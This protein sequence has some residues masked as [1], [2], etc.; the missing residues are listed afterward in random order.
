MKSR[1]RDVRRGGESFNILYTVQKYMVK[2][3]VRLYETSRRKARLFTQNLH[4][5]YNCIVYIMCI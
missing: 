5:V 1:E 2:K 4:I 3:I